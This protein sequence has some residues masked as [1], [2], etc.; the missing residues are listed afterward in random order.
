MGMS[1]P[2][3]LPMVRA[4]LNGMME[5]LVGWFLLTHLAWE[6]AV[7]MVTGVGI[8]WAAR[9]RSRT[10]EGHITPA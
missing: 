7:G 8:Q 2:M 5:S 6:L 10:L 4:P 3:F 9:A 1:V